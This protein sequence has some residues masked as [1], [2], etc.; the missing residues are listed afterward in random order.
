MSE[1]AFCGCGAQS[2][3]I[4]AL[5][6]SREIIIANNYKVVLVKHFCG[7]YAS[8]SW[9]SDDRLSF[10]SGSKGPVEMFVLKLMS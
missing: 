2:I 6:P 9:H 1:F 4:T 10:S 5:F 3:Y 7:V 8:S